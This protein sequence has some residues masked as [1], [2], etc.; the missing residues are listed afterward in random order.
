MTTQLIREAIDTLQC[1]FQEFKAAND[2]RLVELEK[3]GVIDPL[4]EEKVNHLNDEVDKAQK[5]LSHLEI[6]LRKPYIANS[7]E[8]E[9]GEKGAFFAYIRKGEEGFEQKAL[10]SLNDASG[11][12]LIPHGMLDKI[13]STMS[14]ASPMRSLSRITSISTDALELLIEKG[15]ADVGWVAETADRPETRTPELQKI[16]IPVHQIY[17]K[18]RASQKLLD[19]SSVDIES[20][21]AEKIAEKMI[22]TEN[23][24]FINGDGNGKPKGFLTYEK[25]QVGKGE[26]GK[27]EAFQS[28]NGLTDGDI[29]LDIFHA[30]KAHY[31]NGATWVMSRSALA[32]IRKLKDGNRHYLWQ[33]NI[34]ENTPASLLGYPVFIADEMPAL[35]INEPST[36]IAFGNFKQAYQIVDRAGLHVLRDPFS[37]KPYVEFYATK[38]VGGDVVNF[39]ALKFIHFVK[40]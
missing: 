13:H 28:R 1:A 40:E 25:V 38:R 31:L 12:Y 36:S 10:S 30:L 34:S 5:R 26:W 21:L 20:W 3:K 19:D 15:T 16:R 39:D 6:A 32:A 4:V 24:A 2:Q 37:T 18:P 22:L 9:S 27:I 17:A 23:T 35:D 8:Q 11:G 33:P 14:V 29:L 7:N